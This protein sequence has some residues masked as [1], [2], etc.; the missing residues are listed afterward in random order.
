M[1]IEAKHYTP[2]HSLVIDHVKVYSLIEV[3]Y[4][5]A[6]IFVI[7]SMYLGKCMKIV[8]GKGLQKKKKN[9]KKKKKK[10]KTKEKKNKC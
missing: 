7:K 10:R 3:M 5:K 8:L 2:N 4:C 6:L 9:K 1:Q